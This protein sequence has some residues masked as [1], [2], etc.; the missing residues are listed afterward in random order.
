V[1]LALFLSA[2]NVDPVLELV[3]LKCLVV[4]G[5]KLELVGLVAEHF[6]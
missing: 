4:V 2:Q 5:V 1:P 3:S 6:D